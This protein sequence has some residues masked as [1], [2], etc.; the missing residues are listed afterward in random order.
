MP[1]E[2]NHDNSNTIIEEQLNNNLINLELTLKAD[3]LAFRGPIA[4]GFDDVIRDFVEKRRGGKKTKAQKLCVI[5]QTTGGQ[6][7]VTERIA[8]TFRKHYKFVE[9]IIPNYAMSAGTVLV[10]SGDEIYM[11]YYSILGPIDPQVQNRDGVWVPALGYLQEYE[12]LTEKAENDGLSPVE[13]SYL[14]ARFDPAEMYQYKQARELSKKLLE[15]WLVKYKFRNWK[16][17]A[18]KKN[19]VTM[20]VRRERARKIAD[21]LNATSEWC[22]HGRGISMD[23]L[24]RKLGLQI[25]NFE[26]HE[27]LNDRIRTYDRLLSDY[28]SRLRTQ[29][30][31]HVRGHYL[32]L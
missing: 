3:V 21:K 14:V 32:A 1:K 26:K 9:F 4:S 31:F 17:T 12:R 18:T 7:E 22:S 2:K 24:K 10:L 5:L 23:V 28:M 11:D 30:V 15:E 19:K 29:V 27:E 25:I 20:A 13:A 6:I 16:V 8:S